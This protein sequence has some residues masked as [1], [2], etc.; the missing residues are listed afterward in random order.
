MPLPW[1]LVEPVVQ[2]VSILS[3]ITLSVRVTTW[4]RAKLAIRPKRPILVSQ[5]FEIR[6]E[7]SPVHSFERVP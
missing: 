6:P 4:L 1:A 7:N 5:V 3:M 2:K